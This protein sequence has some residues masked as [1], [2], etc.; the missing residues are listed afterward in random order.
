M[1]CLSVLSIRNNFSEVYSHKKCTYFYLHM[2]SLPFVWWS[3][4]N[5]SPWK[6]F[7][8]DLNLSNVWITMEIND[9]LH[10]FKDSIS[11]E[12]SELTI[13]SKS[14]IERPTEMMLLTNLIFDD[15]R[16]CQIVSEIFTLGREKK[17]YQK[18]PTVG[19]E[20]MTSKSSCKCSTIWAMSAFSCKPESSWS[21]KSHA[22]F[23]L[24]MTNV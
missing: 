13:V 21:L 11:R 16:F 14:W 22:F 15:K 6:L 5:N 7:R 10:M 19:I 17:N 20:L 8:P 2:C 4:N 23:I 3:T 1:E 18:L 12:I 9:S 24:E